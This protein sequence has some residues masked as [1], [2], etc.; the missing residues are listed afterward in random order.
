MQSP[1]A[2]NYSRL[3]VVQRRSCMRRNILGDTRRAWWR[4]IVDNA[5]NDD[6]RRRRRRRETTT[7]ERATCRRGAVRPPDC[8]RA[9]LCDDCGD[10]QNRCG[11]GGGDCG[12]THG[13]RAR[14]SQLTRSTRPLSTHSSRALPSLPASTCRRRPPP[15]ANHKCRQ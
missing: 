1:A 2:R 13:A 14:L 10:V 3:T 4:E 15:A 7:T 6:D 11:S 5:L 8:P 9:W 12:A